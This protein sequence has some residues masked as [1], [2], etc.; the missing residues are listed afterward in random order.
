MTQILNGW[1]IDE[2]QSFENITLNSLRASC[3]TPIAPLHH[4]LKRDCY[5]LKLYLPHTEEGME[6]IK[7]EIKQVTLAT[8]EF[9]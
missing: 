5:T 6:V 7:E 1:K 2:E 3:H 4:I 9:F 8:T